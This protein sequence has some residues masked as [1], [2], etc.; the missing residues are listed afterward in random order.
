VDV[1]TLVQREPAT[2]APDAPCAAAARQMRDAGMGSLVVVEDGQPIGMLTDRDLVVR[3]LAAGLDAE[4]VRVRDAMS[5]RP[6]FVTD[7]WDAGAVL[8]LMR[9]LAVR[10]VPVVDERRALVGVVS[11][12]DLLVAL[13]DQLAAVAE[14][15]RKESP[16]PAR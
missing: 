12:D 6:I 1:G 3:V 15:V 5:E 4:K 10:R 16:P 9:D 11:L 7:S 8:R 2:V 13:A 14:L